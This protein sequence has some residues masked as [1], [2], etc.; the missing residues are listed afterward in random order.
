MLR[1]P[2]RLKAQETALDAERKCFEE[3]NRLTSCVRPPP[4][5]ACQPCCPGWN[6]GHSKCPT[7]KCIAYGGEM[8]DVIIESA[9]VFSYGIR[10]Q[11]AWNTEFLWT[12]TD[13]VGGA[14]PEWLDSLDGSDEGPTLGALLGKLLGPN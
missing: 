5:S 7:L 11:A 2:A 14:D 13:C 8:D 4:L 1:L 10:K 9:T 3:E 6:D 12:V